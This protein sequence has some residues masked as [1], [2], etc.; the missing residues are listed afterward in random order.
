MLLLGT[1]LC[2]AVDSLLKL[3]MGFHSEIFVSLFF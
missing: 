2:V 3:A 1:D